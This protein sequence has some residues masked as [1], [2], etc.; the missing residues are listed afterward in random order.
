MASVKNNYKYRLSLEGL[1]CERDERPLFSGLSAQFDSGDIVQLAGANGSGKTT[2]LK[3]L[4]G[5]LPAS[6]GSVVW[7]RSDGD[8]TQS[9]QECLLYLGHQPAVN[10]SLSALENLRWYFG[11]NGEKST[12]RARVMPSRPAL[13]EALAEVGLRGY[14]DVPC[15]QMSAGQHR[16]VALARLYLSRAP[17]WV[18]DEPFT[19]IDKVGVASLESRIARHADDG[20]LVLL[21]THQPLQQLNGVKILDL[22]AFAVDEE[23]CV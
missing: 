10:G 5:I 11:L 18:L 6:V 19:A 22:K 3:L 15:S 23:V 14:E 8:D 16:R 1:A 13:I 9:L 20:G 7:Q 12:D 17:L 4:I 21:T 2:L